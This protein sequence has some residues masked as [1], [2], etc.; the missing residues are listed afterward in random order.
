MNS[1]TPPVVID[2]WSDLV[3]P[4]CWIAR[5]R[6][7]KALSQH[8]HKDDIE[9]RYH[10]YRLS[11]AVP[12]PYI[13]ALTTRYGNTAA[14]NSM[15]KRVTEA[16]A[17]DGLVYN[18]D[19]MLFGDTLDAHVLIAAARR[20]GLGSQMI[21]HLFYESTT[22]GRSIFDRKELY[23]MAREVGMPDININEI[24]TDGAGRLF[25]MGCCQI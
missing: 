21:N 23:L 13:E 6:F 16:G 10:A 14:I 17:E 25:L 4:W 2:V 22:R 7:E 5:T 15:M 8:D 1:N 24:L 11:D 18:F 19:S 12:A 9:V 3:C 20:V